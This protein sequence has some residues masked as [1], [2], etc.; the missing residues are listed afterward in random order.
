MR[1]LLDEMLPRQLGPL[2]SGHEVVH[3]EEKGWKSYSNG[4]L[5]SLAETDGIDV[6]ITKDR[7]LSYQQNVTGRSI[8]IVVIKPRGQSRAAVLAM[9]EDIL[10][11]L[12]NLPRG[13][14]TTVSAL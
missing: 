5:L 1:V 4:K 10:N 7:N 2:L 13:T 11:A 12:L 9:C 14:V 6:L 3:V 8:S